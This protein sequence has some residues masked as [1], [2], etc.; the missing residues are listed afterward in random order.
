MPNL[1]VP[2]LYGRSW[3]IMLVLNGLL[4]LPPPRQSVKSNFPLI[5][6]L[7]L[8]VMMVTRVLI[9]TTSE[10]AHQWII[11]PLVMG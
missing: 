7:Q 2:G 8:M 11:L 10:A 4:V 6:V 3:I 5:L 9:L 1:V